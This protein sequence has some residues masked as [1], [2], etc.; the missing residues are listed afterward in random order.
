LYA[1]DLPSALKQEGRF[2][3]IQSLLKTVHPDFGFELYLH[4]EL[5]HESGLGLRCRLGAT[6]GA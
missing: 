4:S 1:D 2:G 5:S 6:W 3:L